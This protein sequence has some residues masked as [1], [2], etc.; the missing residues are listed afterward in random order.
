MV[1]PKASQENLKIAA[2]FAEAVTVTFPEKAGKS[3]PACLPVDCKGSRSIFSALVEAI[4]DIVR[5][6]SDSNSIHS[7]VSE[8]EFNKFIARLGYTSFRYRHRIRGT[9]DKWS[10]GVQRWKH[11][12]WVN[13][14]DSSDLS[15]LRQGLA[16]LRSRFPCQ[17]TLNEDKIIRF[18][19][20]ISNP[21]LDANEDECHIMKEF[22]TST[23]SVGWKPSNPCNQ[24]PIKC[25]TF[26]AGGHPQCPTH[27]VGNG[28]DM[29]SA[30]AQSGKT[31]QM[32]LIPR[33]P[34]GAPNL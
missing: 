33:S 10:K 32:E 20:S 21:L 2:T 9:V 7:T 8:V 14:C 15:H 16:D 26:P 30:G 23:D 12:R 1:R 3:M 34:V 24:R 25:D 31:S 17:Q 5:Q 28:M 11:V 29:G 6:S 4:P 19:Q 13:P 27:W 18:L 22:G